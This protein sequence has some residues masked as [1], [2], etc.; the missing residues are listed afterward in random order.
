MLA[1]IYQ[2]LIRWLEYGLELLIGAEIASP[3]AREQFLVFTHVVRDAP[4]SFRKFLYSEH[5]VHHS[6]TTIC[7][8]ISRLRHFIL[9]NNQEIRERFEVTLACMTKHI[10]LKSRE[11]F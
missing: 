4:R 10:Y 6:I 11:T 2:G 7:T 8:S 1:V 5:C 3:H 9:R